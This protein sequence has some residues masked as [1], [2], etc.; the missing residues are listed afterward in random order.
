MWVPQS[1]V[2]IFGQIHSRCERL[3]SP[4]DEEHISKLQRAFT[5]AA[6]VWCRT[7]ARV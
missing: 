7:E 4:E 5:F 2:V 3:M 6:D 1:V